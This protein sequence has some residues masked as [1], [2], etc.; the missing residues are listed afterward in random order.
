M[1]DDNE[2]FI[3]KYLNENNGKMDSNF[4]HQ[5]LGIAAIIEYFIC[6]A[7]PE[8]ETERIRNIQNAYMCG[9][10]DQNVSNCDFSSLTQ[11][12]FEMLKFNERTR[13]NKETIDRF[14]PGEILKRKNTK[15]KDLTDNDNMPH[16]AILDGLIINLDDNPNLIIKN[17]VDE[18]I[19]A[20]DSYHGRSVYSIF[21]SIAPNCTI[22]FYG[23]D[24]IYE[25][26]SDEDTERDRLKA[27]QDIIEYNNNCTD[28]SKKIK[29]ISC[30]HTLSLEEKELIASSK[31]NVISAEN[32]HGDFFEYFKFDDK[33]V[34]PFITEEE[35]KDLQERYSK[36]PHIVKRIEKMISI[37]DNAILMNINLVIDQ[38][39]GNMKRH[40]CNV[41]VSWG[42]PVVA[43]YYAI[44][45]RANP[46]MSYEE[47]RDIC[48]KSLKEKTNIFDEDLFMENLKEI[49][50]EKSIF[51]EEE[52]GKAT[53]NVPTIQKDESGKKVKND[54]IIQEEIKNL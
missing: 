41:S 34:I 17:Y 10:E 35:K 37:I 25:E 47:F 33:D 29:L 19:R 46:N 30:S 2:N 43:A 52:I 51:S 23:T 49:K 5:Y 21:S 44:A 13:F 50:Q 45:L 18:S 16:I 6:R 39:Y 26:K 7:Q 48:K 36:Y 9:I 15:I 42:V 8:I 31:V 1:S 38:H 53:V 40:E 32:L 4:I 12:E 14:H 27:L 3:K 20:T 24:P 54:W 22:H 11:E 28:D